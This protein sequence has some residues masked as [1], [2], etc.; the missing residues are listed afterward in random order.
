MQ[1]SIIERIVSCCK[2]GDIE[3][4]VGVL[5]EEQRFERMRGLG[6][7]WHGQMETLQARHCSESA[8]KYF[9]SMKEFVLRLAGLLDIGEGNIPFLPVILISHTS[10]QQ[11]IAM[12]SKGGKTGTTKLCDHEIITDVKVPGRMYFIFDVGDGRMVLGKSPEDAEKSISTAHR[13]PLIIE[14]AIALA[15]HTDVLSSHDVDAICSSHTLHSSDSDGVL[16]IR[17]NRDD[18]SPQ[19][20]PI[21]AQSFYEKRGSASC[22]LRI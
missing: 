4:A 19:I 17:T 16:Q 9:K 20:V 15:I 13:L 6:D 2:V 21:T 8:L 7:L 3:R 12:V 22:V 14:E 11:L 5:R 1:N 18:S 10:I